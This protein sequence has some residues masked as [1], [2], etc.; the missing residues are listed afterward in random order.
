MEK[1]SKSFTVDEIR[2][3]LM[4]YCA[5]QD[6]CHWEVERKLAEFNLIPEAYDEILIYLIENKF[7]NEER[8]VH[9]FVRGKFKLKKWGRIKIQIELK[10]RKIPTKLIA[11]ALKSID[12][13]EYTTTLEELFKKK[14]ESLRSEKESFKKK[15]KIRNF[16]LQKGYESELIYEI[17][18]KV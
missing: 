14:K 6:R 4:K 11:E 16:L 5:Y 10:K 13:I 9:S 15:A 18:N 3:K 1:K 7:L 2:E 12:E 8:F 17:Q